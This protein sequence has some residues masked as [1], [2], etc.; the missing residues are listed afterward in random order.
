MNGA[1]VTLAQPPLLLKD[2]VYVTKEDIASLPGISIEYNQATGELTSKRLGNTLFM[3]IGQPLKAGDKNGAVPFLQQGIVYLPLC[4][5]ISRLNYNTQT[6]KAPDGTIVIILEKLGFDFTDYLKMV[7][8]TRFSADE[9]KAAETAL[10]QGITIT[11]LQNH[12]A[13]INEGVQADGRKDNGKPYPIAFTDI[14]SVT[15]GADGHY[16]Y[17]KYEFYD[18]LPEKLFY[19]ENPDLGLTD[20]ISGLG[21]GF[22]LSNFFNRDTGKDDVGGM[23][24]SLTWVQ[25]DSQRYTD[26]PNLFAPPVVA[27][28]NQATLT[29]GKFDNGDD[30]YNIDDVNGL[31]AGGAG[32]NYLMAAFPLKEYGLQLG[33]IIEGSLGIEV[34]S[35]LFHHECCDVVLDCG[36]KAGEIIRYELGAN[37]YENLGPGNNLIPLN[38][39]ATG[40]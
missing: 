38:T 28:Q 17:L 35:K 3:K 7:T 24:I 16:M 11:D 21:G 30:R 27:V 4:D 37:S 26:N 10:A 31:V 14:K 6:N 15:L 39:S 13:L 29:G 22:F 36:F 5:V 18:V 25:G 9:L 20:F 33:D 32:T 34:G 23:S 12:W 19:F 40:K 2:V 1:D 8:S